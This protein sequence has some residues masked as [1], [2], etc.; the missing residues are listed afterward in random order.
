MTYIIHVLSVYTSAH[1][2]LCQ[3]SRGVEEGGEWR[4]WGGRGVEEGS[5]GG[6]G[7]GGA[8]LGFESLEGASIKHSPAHS[9]PKW[10]LHISVCLA[11]GQGT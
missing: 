8:G 6:G 3:E 2:C 4:R 9:A 10:I 11:G 7:G 5:G 1:V